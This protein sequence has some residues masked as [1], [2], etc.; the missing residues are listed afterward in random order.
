MTRTEIIQVVSEI[1]NAHSLRLNESYGSELCSMQWH[2]AGTLKW[3]TFEQVRLDAGSGWHDAVE[4]RFIQSEIESR[5]KR[6]LLTFLGRSPDNNVDITINRVNYDADVNHFREQTELSVE[7][8][9]SLKGLSAVELHEEK[10]VWDRGRELDLLPAGINYIPFPENI[11]KAI[12]DLSD[13]YSMKLGTSTHFNADNYL[14]SWRN[15]KFVK[16]LDFD[17]T[18]SIYK[19]YVTVTLYCRERKTVLDAITNLLGLFGVSH[20]SAIPN[21]ITTFENIPVGLVQDDY[22]RTIEGIIMQSLSTDC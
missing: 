9:K 19:G 15:G 1:A 13:K 7:L 20:P 21:I 8:A 10:R 4:I 12:L 22:H 2:E 16:M 17:S 11:A 3:I 14:L 5:W 6:A 18:I